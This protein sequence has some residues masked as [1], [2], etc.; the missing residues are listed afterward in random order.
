MLRV[1]SNAVAIR[2][3]Y[4]TPDSRFSR[5]ITL[6]D[7]ANN[8]SNQ[9]ISAC[10]TFARRTGMRHEIGC[11]DG[12]GSVLLHQLLPFENDLNRPTH[13]PDKRLSVGSAPIRPNNTIG[14]PVTSAAAQREAGYRSASQRQPYRGR[15]RRLKGNVRAGRGHC[16]HRF[17]CVTPR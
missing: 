8:G 10:S 4:A 16:C 2:L 11:G 3:L 15:L 14:R 12:P 17:Y 9:C 7:R 5:A 6:L 1:S 13:S